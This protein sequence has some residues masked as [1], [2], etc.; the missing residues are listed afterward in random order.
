MKYAMALEDSKASVVKNSLILLILFLLFVPELALASVGG[1]EMCIRDSNCR[2]RTNFGIPLNNYSSQ[3]F[4]TK[5]FL[6]RH[7]GSQKDRPAGRA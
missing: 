3:T 7:Y 1:G 4:N 6:W 5:L 2:H